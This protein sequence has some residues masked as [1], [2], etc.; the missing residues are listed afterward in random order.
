[1]A[2]FMVDIDMHE[3]HSEA[4][5]RLIPSQRAVVNDLMYEGKITSYC[6]SMDRKKLWMVAVARDE[7]EV[8]EFLAKFPL[9]KFMDCEI[10]PLLFS[11]SAQQTFSHISLN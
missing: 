10:Q 5:M 6:V 11:N 9:I 8:M 3:A 1:M 4:F 2:E 7:D